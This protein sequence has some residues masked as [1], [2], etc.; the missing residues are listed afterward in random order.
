MVFMVSVICSGRVLGSLGL[1]GLLGLLS[2]FL[3]GSEGLELKGVDPTLAG[4][5]LAQEGVDHTVAG[6]LHLGPERLGG[7][8][9]SA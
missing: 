3:F 4:H 7:N 8:D 1:G 9:K 6:G 2:L 5:L